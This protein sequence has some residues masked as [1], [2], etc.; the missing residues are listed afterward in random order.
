MQVMLSSW[1]G[2]NMLRVA[3]GGVG[4]RLASWVWLVR[5]PGRKSR[6][7]GHGSISGANA[8]SRIQEHVRLPGLHCIQRFLSLPEAE[9]LGW[10]A[11]SF[12]VAGAHKQVLVKE[13][14][15]GLSCFVLN[16]VW[17]VYRSCDF[18]AEWSA[19]WWSRVGAWI[20]RM[21]HRFV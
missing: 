5:V 14:E 6:L 9:G 16:E 12:D 3:G 4:W 2:V 19:Y 1:K 20:V 10:V 7:I 18:G 11:F 13:E 17:Y 15:Q 21:L 8:A